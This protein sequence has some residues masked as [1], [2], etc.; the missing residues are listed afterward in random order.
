MS[1]YINEIESYRIAVALEKNEHNSLGIK[2]VLAE[3][4][5]SLTKN[6]DV[7][8][9]D[10]IAPEVTNGELWRER[11]LAGCGPKIRD[12]K[13]DVYWSVDHKVKAADRYVDEYRKRFPAKA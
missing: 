1:Q 5:D 4:K 8:K 6:N 12:G 2:E 9:E 7:K 13:G 10:P 3:I 11:F